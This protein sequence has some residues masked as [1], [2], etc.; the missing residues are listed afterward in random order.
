M[1]I[2][3][4]K[5]SKENYQGVARA[6][7]QAAN[8]ADRVVDRVKTGAHEIMNRAE[9]FDLAARYNAIKDSA[10]EGYDTAIRTVKKYPLYAVG[11]AAAIGV[12]A[13]LLL[14]RRRH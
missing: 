3:S 7:D 13:G 12:L 9:D 6:A 1:E 10:A 8:K 11:G 2:N 14:S 5:A 4:T